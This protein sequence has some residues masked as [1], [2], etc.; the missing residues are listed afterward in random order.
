MSPLEKKEIL[1]E[2]FRKRK[3]KRQGPIKTIDDLKLDILPETFEWFR[4]LE[5]GG[6]N[7]QVT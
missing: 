5:R 7:G 2:E 4:N 1:K 6:D 3:A